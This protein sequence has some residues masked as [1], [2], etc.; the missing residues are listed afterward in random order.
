LFGEGDKLLGVYPVTVGSQESPS[1]RLKVT[2]ISKNPTYRYD[3][4]YAFKG[5]RAKEPFTRSIVKIRPRRTQ[6][7]P[8]V[9][10]PHVRLLGAAS[11]IIFARISDDVIIRTQLLETNVAGIIFGSAN[12]SL[13]EPGLLEKEQ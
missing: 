3:P 10:Y 13:G 4:K 8:A 2:G 6:P 5:V 9:A 7:I 12:K 11:L 1:G